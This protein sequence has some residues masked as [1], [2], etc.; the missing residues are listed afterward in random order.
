MDPSPG[1][2][3]HRCASLLDFRLRALLPAFRLRRPPACGLRFILSLIVVFWQT[4]ANTDYSPRTHRLGGRRIDAPPS[5]PPARVHCFLVS[6]VDAHRL[7]G[8]L[9][10]RCALADQDKAGKLMFRELERDLSM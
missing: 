6:V 2:Q 3:A 1:R 5:H 4:T 7:V 8:P 10:E 9:A